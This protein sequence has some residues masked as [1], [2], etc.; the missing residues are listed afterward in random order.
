MFDREKDKEI[1]KLAAKAVGI[2]ACWCKERYGHRD[3][4]SVREGWK[5]VKDGLVYDWWN[6]LIDDGDAL[7]MAVKLKI[8]FDQG[9]SEVFTSG[10]CEE[11]HVVVPIDGD[12]L[13][14]TRRA[15]VRAAAEIGKTT[16]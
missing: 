4:P 7:R 13:A 16:T 15:I 12:P 10:P 5:E 2:S 14:A 1:L 11:A 8:T 3:E 6:P 9:V